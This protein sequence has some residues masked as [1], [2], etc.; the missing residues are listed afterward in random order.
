MIEQFKRMYLNKVVY[1]D[2]IMDDELNTLFEKV[3]MDEFNDDPE[4]MSNLIEEIRAEAIPQPPSQD[5]LIS[6]LQNQL[7]YMSKLLNRLSYNQS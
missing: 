1:G 6:D 2:G 7:E 5:E 4:K 3:L